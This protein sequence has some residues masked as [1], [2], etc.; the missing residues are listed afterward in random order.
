[1]AFRLFDRFAGEWEVREL[2]ANIKAQTFWRRIIG[3]YTFSEF[4]E[5]QE[6][7]AAY[8]REFVV[9]RFRAGD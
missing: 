4:T 6:F 1:V 9:Q 3:D 5:G 8:E 7:F 2:P